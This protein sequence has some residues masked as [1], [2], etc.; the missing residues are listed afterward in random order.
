MAQV[1]GGQE[2]SDGLKLVAW[3]DVRDSDEFDDSRS[4]LT[5]D[6]E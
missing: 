3:M 5:E 4:D 1:A 2:A 6:T